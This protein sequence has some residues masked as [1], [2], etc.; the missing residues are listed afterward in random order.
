VS[1]PRWAKYPILTL[2]FG[3]IGMQ[4]VQVEQLREHA[5]RKAH[6][7]EV[8]RR[9]DAAQAASYEAMLPGGPHGAAPRLQQ[10][11]ADF[12]A[13]TRDNPTQQALVGPLLEAEADYLDVLGSGP[14]GHSPAALRA[15]ADLRR[16]LREAEAEEDRLLVVRHAALEQRLATVRLLTYAMLAVGFVIDAVE[17]LTRPTG[18]R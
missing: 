8:I 7:Y 14:D 12:A 16:L 5:H 6:T 3:L 13:R 4:A 18:G 1:V 17:R 10:A 2:C 11:L 15:G 9:L